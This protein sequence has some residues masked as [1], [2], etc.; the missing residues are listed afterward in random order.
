ML[1]AR[2][3][4]QRTVLASVCTQI[5]QSC[6]TLRPHGL[7]LSRLLCPWD[8]PG[9]NIGVGCSFLLQG[10]FPTQE[11]NL[12]LRVSCIAGRFFTAES[13]FMNRIKVA[14]SKNFIHVTFSKGVCFPNFE[15]QCVSQI[16]KKCEDWHIIMNSFSLSLNGYK[17]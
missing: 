5:S 12:H 11:L 2:E 4:R 13:P 17:F 8:F 7:Q 15:L 3:G 16:K 6:L 9:K 10:I 14:A 1:T